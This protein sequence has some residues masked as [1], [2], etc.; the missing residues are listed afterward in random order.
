ME[1]SGYFKVASTVLLG[2]FLCCHV[3]FVVQLPL[4]SYIRQCGLKLE[5]GNIIGVNFWPRVQR[6]LGVIL[7]NT[8]F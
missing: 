1:N 7:L 4:L 8:L 2:E 5:M 6:G 3:V